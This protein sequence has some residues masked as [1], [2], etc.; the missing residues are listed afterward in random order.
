[1]NNNTDTISIVGRIELKD[2]RVYSDEKSDIER[3]IVNVGMTGQLISS[4][5]ISSSEEIIM[6]A[7]NINSCRIEG[8]ENIDHGVDENHLGEEIIS[9]TKQSFNSWEKQV[10]IMSLYRNEFF[11]RLVYLLLYYK[12]KILFRP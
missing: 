6:S 9:N 10:K 8:H 1:M 12:T 7:D 5:N 2:I 11:L 4:G 3:S